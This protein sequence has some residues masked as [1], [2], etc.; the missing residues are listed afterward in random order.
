MPVKFRVQIECSKKRIWA[1]IPFAEGWGPERARRIPDAKFKKIGTDSYWHYPL[2]LATCHALRAEFGTSLHIGPRLMEW[3]WNEADRQAELELLRDPETDFDLERTKKLAPVLFKALQ[4]RPYQIAGIGF[5]VVGKHVLLGDQPGLGKTYQALGAVVESGCTRVLVCCPRTATRTVWERHVAQ[6][7]GPKVAR[8][9]VAQGTRA[10]RLKV[11][12]RFNFASSRNDGK[13]HILII[14]NEMIRVHR[15]WRCPSLKKGTKNENKWSRKAPGSKDGC[16]KDHK[17]GVRYVAEYPMLFAKPWE[18]LVL[19]ESHHALASTYNRNSRHITQIRLGAVRLPSPPDGY[20]LPMSGTPAS[21]KLPRFWGTM[22][23]LRPDVFGSF[24]SFAERHFEVADNKYG[25]K[26]LKT[27]KPRDP[28]RF[29]DE[30][31]PYYLARTKRQ[32]A[33]DLPPVT[34]AGTPPDDNP[35]GRNGIYLDM[36]G[37]QAK[38]YADM[39]E[40]AAAHL[41]D[42][43]RLT[44]NGILAEIMRLK[45]FANSWARLEYQNPDHDS[46]IRVYPELPSNKLE[47]ILDFLDE[48]EGNEGKIVVASCFTKYINLMAEQFRHEGFPCLTL[49]GQTTDRGRVEVQDRWQND[50][51]DDARVLAMNSKAGGEAITLDAADDMIITD[52]PWTSDE[53]QQTIDRIHRVSRIHAVTVYNLRSVGTVDDWIA[54]LTHEQR[55]ALESA[56]PA[57]VRPI[58]DAWLRGV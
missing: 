2:T 25:G 6:L 46:P 18:F 40:L 33:P 5:I 54:G 21:S 36:D 7:L 31:R 20:R 44:A 11:M 8:T 15:E 26:T 10:D 39:K 14:N 42:D 19:D 4:S 37:E 50:P 24:W 34:Y 52:S 3:A 49:T 53:E 45:Q 17:H 56:R 30:L 9:Y 16:P 55:L 57:V 29:A 47:W 27:V 43:K 35:D 28:K 32:V 41:L 51:D 22:N 23:V 48:R 58:I 38:A 1:K 13:I 12:E